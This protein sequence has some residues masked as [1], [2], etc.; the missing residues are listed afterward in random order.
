M[1]KHIHGSQGRAAC[2]CG[3][4]YDVELVGKIM[5]AIEQHNEEKAITP[6]PAC[7]RDAMLLVAALA[8]FDSVRLTLVADKAPTGKRLSELF[9]ERAYERIET[10]LN[11][12][13][14]RVELP[15]AAKH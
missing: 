14:D 6:C 5:Q 8:H 2:N 9:A 1:S 4:K 11:V 10:A 13:V 3:T 7:F 12:L 15:H